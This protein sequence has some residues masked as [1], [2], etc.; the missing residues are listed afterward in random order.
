[1]TRC[2]KPLVPV[3]ALS[4]LLLAPIVARAAEEPGTPAPDAQ[5]T[6]TPS[7]GSLVVEPIRDTFVIAP[8]VKLTEMD[9]A[10]RTLVGA[11]GGWLKENTLLIGGAGYWLADHSRDRE[12]AYGG[13]VVQWT[14]PAARALRVGVRGLIG[15]GQGTVARTATY[16]VP[17]G[18]DF[19]HMRP[20]DWRNIDLS[21]RT[22]TGRFRYRSGFLVAEP[23]ADIVLGVTRWLAVNAGVGY[24]AIGWASGLERQFRGVS[25]SLGLRIGRS[26]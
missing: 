8:D 26:S 13:L 17:D 9:H 12:L 21:T 16:R 22:V 15:G 11:Y 3:L 5:K 6:G 24:R 1:M 7:P 10:T 2:R 25:G 20:F 19:N 4:L 23:Q 18:L 14:I